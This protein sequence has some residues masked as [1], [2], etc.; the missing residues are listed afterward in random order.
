VHERGGELHA[1]LVAQR[2][3]L[4][5][6][7]GVLGDAEALDPLARRVLRGGLVAAVQLGEVAQ[8][9]IDAHLRIQPALLGHV[10]EQALLLA[11][12]GC[13]VPQHLAGVGLEH[14]EGDAHRRG[15]ARAVGTDEADDVA[16]GNLER[17]AVQRDGLPVAARE[18][19]EFE[20]LTAPSRSRHGLHRPD[21][22]RSAGGSAGL[23]RG[24]QASMPR[25]R[26]NYDLPK[27]PPLPFRQAAVM[28]GAV[29]LALG[30]WFLLPNSPIVVALIA[31]IVLAG[32]FLGVGA[33]LRS[34]ELD[35]KP[36]RNPVTPPSIDT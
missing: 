14:A 4:D 25:E 26:E 15:L 11:G 21:L 29:V 20:H 5:A 36:G 8:V 13:P 10:A 27:R 19:A 9:A 34:K 1:L 23:V 22:S 17:Q 33:V 6:L 31:V 2:E 24:T 16:V 28:F 18:V 32:V 12:D 7:L 30:L 35:E 3:L